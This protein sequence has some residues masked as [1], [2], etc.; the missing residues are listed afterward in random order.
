[1]TEPAR[2]APPPAR[3]LAAEARRRFGRN[4]AAM[5]SVLVLAAIV[6]FS[7][8]GPL[9][10]PHGYDQVFPSYVAVGPSLT[11]RPDPETLQGVAE[12][13]ARRAHL[14]LAAFAVEGDGFTA[15]LTAA[16]PIDPRVLRYFDRIDEFEA[17][18]VIEIS[19]DAA[20]LRIAG[21]V[22]RTRFV[23]GTD[24]NGRDLLVRIMLGGQISLSVGLAASLV[25][26]GIG[27]AYGATAGY[28]G[29]RIDDLMM[30][31]VEILYS[32]PFIFIVVMLVVFFGR[33]I[34]LIFLVIG[35]VQWLDMA[36][37]VRGQTLS[38]KR[39]E[40]VTA[41]EALGLSDMAIIRR[42]IVP[43]TIGPVVVFVTA[44][45]PQVILL[46]SFLSFLGLGV[47]APLASWGT[48]IADG[49]HAMQS[50]P[51]ML[52]FPALFFVVTLFALNFAGDG[53]RDALD[54]RER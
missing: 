20:T 51:W 49:A 6:L 11:P 17:T 31:F 28:F 3:S 24:S 18:R 46:E 45:V 21:T 50:A 12:A 38:L 7:F 4:R 40:F 15:T 5:A 30:R 34:G 8:L 2:P 19:M 33:S 43:N 39:R 54:P 1:M 13:A 36:R 26:L 37:I 44:V 27:V 52:V 42:H 41:A 53:L 14:T 32:L 25:S 48:L 22:A 10:V 29:G 47:Q 23:M 16:R 35:A 9:F